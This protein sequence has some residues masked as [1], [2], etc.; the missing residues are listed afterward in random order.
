ME[1]N[2]ILLHIHKTIKDFVYMKDE[3]PTEEQKV[4][5]EQFKISV[6]CLTLSKAQLQE[7]I[8]YI[9]LKQRLRSLE[10]GKE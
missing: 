5:F 2:I 3:N 6:H 10:S 9:R 7:Q 8:A 4:L 1:T